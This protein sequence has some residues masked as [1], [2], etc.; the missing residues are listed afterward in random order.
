MSDS[1]TLY[2]SH[3]GSDFT[4]LFRRK[5]LPDELGHGDTEALSNTLGD[6]N[7]QAKLIVGGPQT[8]VRRL[9]YAE[10]EKRHL[11][12]LMPF[13]LEEEVV[14]DIDQFHFAFGTPAN[15]EI[16]LVYTERAPLQA[17]FSALTDI[18]V[19][20]VQALPAALLPSCPTETDAQEPADIWAIHWQD[21]LVSVRFGESAGFTINANNFNVAIELLLTSQNRVTPPQL[22]LSAPDESQLEQLQQQLPASLSIAQGDTRIC[23]L[24]D[25][26]ADAGTID[27]CQREFS[28]RLPIERWW[29]NWR[30]VAY[31]GVAALVVYLATLLFSINQLQNDN[32]EIRRNIEQVFRTVVPNGPAIDP[33]RR[34]RIM[35]RD[36]EP[37]TGGS[38]V[39]VL[40]DRVL[41]AVAEGGVTLKGVY[42]SSDNAELSLNLQAETF[43]AIESLRGSLEGQ[44]LTAE[45]LSASA[46]GNTHAARIRVKQ[47]LQ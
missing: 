33:E 38:A 15:G 22:K 23:S 44:G 10:A 11:R 34:L 18:N 5:D 24:W 21:Q 39:M 30:K 43:N 9:S 14:G 16:N 19:E 26:E 17:L 2:I 28:Q 31:V 46:Q 29:G 41:P 1:L 7:H 27:L 6:G 4:W 45:L 37:S 32:L 40:L 36:L 25:F 12:K 47:E 8:V 42:Y 3:Y 13:Q 35:A 20:V